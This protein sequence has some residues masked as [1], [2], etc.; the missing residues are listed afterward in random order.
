MTLTFK[1]RRTRLPVLILTNPIRDAF[2]VLVARRAQRICNR[3]RG[4]ATRYERAHLS[5]KAQTQ[6]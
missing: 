4:A 5:L 1:S 6:R 2:P 3:D